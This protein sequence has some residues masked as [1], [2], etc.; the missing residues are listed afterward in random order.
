VLLIT[1][2]LIF[3]IACFSSAFSISLVQLTV[4]RFVTGLGLGA[5]MPNAVTL[6]SEYCPD[7]RRAT[8]VNLMFCGFPLISCISLLVKQAAHP[9]S[10]SSA[11]RV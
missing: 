2:V 5:A 8:M 6:M 3:G 4:L 1:S 10:A 11:R 7:G 9:Q